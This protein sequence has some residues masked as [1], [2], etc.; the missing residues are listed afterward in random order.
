MVPRSQVKFGLERYQ[1]KTYLSLMIIFHLT[2]VIMSD[3]SRA[4][5]LSYVLSYV[6]ES[7]FL[8]WALG[9]FA[10]FL[11]AS[12]KVKLLLHNLPSS[13]LARD[14]ASTNQKGI[15]QLAILAPYNKSLASSVAAALVPTLLG[16]ATK[17]RSLDDSNHQLR[18]RQPA[19]APGANQQHPDTNPS[20]SST[21]Q[22][23][24][25][26][27]MVHQDSLKRRL[28]A[29]APTSTGDSAQPIISTVPEVY[30][31]P[32]TPTPSLANLPIIT[33]SSPSRR[34]SLASRRGSDVSRISR[35]ASECSVRFVGEDE[36]I[37]PAA[38]STGKRSAEINAA[39]P[40]SSPVF[41]RSRSP[42]T[43]ILRRNSDCP[44]PT[45]P[46]GSSRDL[47]RCSDFGQDCNG[48]QVGRVS[49]QFAN[50]LRRN[51]DFGNRTPRRH[52][53]DQSTL[54]K[55]LD[56]SPVGSRRNS[57]LGVLSPT[58]RA[59]ESR[60]NSDVSCRST[61]RR[62]LDLGIRG[63]ASRRS[64]DTGV[65]V[66]AGGPDDSEAHLSEIKSES[67][68]E[69]QDGDCGSEKV[70]LVNG[71]STNEEPKTPRKKNLSW[72]SDRL[73]DDQEDIT[74]ETS[75]LKDA[76]A[77]TGI[78]G[79]DFTLHSILNH[80]A[81]VNRARSDMPLHIPEASTAAARRSQLR[82]VLNV[83]YA[84]AILGILLCVADVARIFG[85]YG[86]L[87]GS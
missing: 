27:T 6:V 54:A 38:E 71:G 84:T 1:K 20:L 67:D 9:L 18:L 5:H 36:V 50:K 85:P 60:R 81:Y 70:A 10:T 77:A 49:S 74:P 72:K 28:M 25:P 24:K 44:S 3:T 21:Q 32:P 22:R 45:S 31:R 64:S 2:C 87:A 80:I 33:V 79:A 63:P 7:I 53:P 69:Q 78:T 13:L 83:T 61:D 66:P 56:V 29:D 73:A 16:P 75:L 65:R 82:K 76:T 58:P 55:I 14:S 37:S 23:S 34:S 62:S 48:K 52:E 35:R 68:S 19:N 41:D 86:E 39:S 51:S 46:S 15:M 8:V 30:V 17:L 11:Y 42:E 40:R 59:V 47:R 43:G 4:F 12:H 26:A 57:D